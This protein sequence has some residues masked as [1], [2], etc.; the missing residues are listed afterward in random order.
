MANASQAILDL[1][2]IPFHLKNNT[3]RQATRSSAST[4]LGNR[5]QRRRGSGD[6]Y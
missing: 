4:A 5:E 2:L 1:G 6:L 3:H